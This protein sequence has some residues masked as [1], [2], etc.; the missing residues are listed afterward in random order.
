M[1]LCVSLV[2]RICVGEVTQCAPVHLQHWVGVSDV[3]PLVWT[4]A[5]GGYFFFPVFLNTSATKKL[6]ISI[7]L[8]MWEA[9][10]SGFAVFTHH[11]GKRRVAISGDVH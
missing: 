6:E 5:E 3:A 1:I 9:L 7:L 2:R 8:Q 10:F 11:D 4:K